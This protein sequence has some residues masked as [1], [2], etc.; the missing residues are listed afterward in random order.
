VRDNTQSI[1]YNC[2]KREWDI[3]YKTLCRYPFEFLSKVVNCHNSTLH[4]YF[5]LVLIGSKAI[6]AEPI[7][8]DPYKYNLDSNDGYLYICEH[9]RQLKS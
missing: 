2:I 9:Y 3:D 5:T 8:L 6:E 7:N 1:H 4:N